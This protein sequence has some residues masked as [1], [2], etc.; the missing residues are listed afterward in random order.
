MILT[1]KCSILENTFVFNDTPYKE[2]T[3][4]KVRARYGLGAQR[5]ISSRIRLHPCYF[6]SGF[7]KWDNNQPNEVLNHEITLWNRC[8]APVSREV[9]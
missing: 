8:P 5:S 2:H 3:V 9:P 6:L 7:K 1:I 4:Q